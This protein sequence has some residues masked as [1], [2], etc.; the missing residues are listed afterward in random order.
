MIFFFFH[1][2]DICL[3]LSLLI[4][5]QD[6]LKSYIG[7]FPQ[8]PGVHLVE[9]HGLRYIQVPQTLPSPRMGRTSFPQYLARAPEMWEVRLTVKTETKKM[10]NISV[11]SLSVVASSSVLLIA[12]VHFL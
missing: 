5:G 12:E 7:Q 1:A 8:A 2:L 10:L 4:Y 9:F 11:F 6:W 3:L